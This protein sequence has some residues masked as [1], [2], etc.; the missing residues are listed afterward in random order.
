MREF[1]RSRWFLISLVGSIIAGLSLGVLAPQMVEQGIAR[2]LNAPA[3]T[4][5]VFSVLFLMSVTLNGRNLTGALLSPQPVLW[6]IV[7]N[8]GLIPLIAAPLM[9]L[10]RHPDLSI[11]LLAA[12]SVPTTMAAA[13]VWTR[14]AGGND[15]ISLMVTM[16]TNSL[17]FLVTPFWLNLLAQTTVELD[18]GHMMRRLMVTALLPIVLGQ[19]T[20][21]IPGCARFADRNKTPLGV[22]AQIGVLLIV[23]ESACSAA[24]RL[25]SEA[26]A[27]R[28]SAFV[29][30]VGA[31]LLVAI[32][33]LVVHVVGMIV[34]DAGCRLL[35]H[36]AADRIAVV[37]SGS[38]KT[39]PIGVLIATDDRMLGSFQW[40]V[41]PILIYH[42]L[43]LFF[44]TAVADRHRIR[45]SQLAQSVPAETTSQ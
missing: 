28:E 40:A 39:L 43:Q 10:Q 3:R 33:C 11:G 45:Q 9:P 24:T 34:A 5:I 29:P 13:S 14:R 20:R 6:A 1:L 38:Q 8:A 25:T 41:C 12:A 31:F 32:S 37:I 44:D 2:V 17:C 16:M 35:R 21:L 36:S 19:V 27:A 42:A 7:V 23:F 26:N 15:G 18:A 22:G 30:S 4:G